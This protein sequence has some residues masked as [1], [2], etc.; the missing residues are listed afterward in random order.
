MSAARLLK[1]GIVVGC[2]VLAGRAIWERLAASDGPDPVSGSVYRDTL[3]WRLYDG[4]PRPQ[5]AA[6]AGTSC[7]RRSASRC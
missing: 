2:G 1:G 5:T 3:G 4:P 7:R 6:S